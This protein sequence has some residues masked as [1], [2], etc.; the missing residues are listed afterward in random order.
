[1]KLYERDGGVFVL[2][3]STF[4]ESMRLHRIAQEGGHVKVRQVYCFEAGA[5][6]RRLSKFFALFRT[7][8]VE[9]YYGDRIAYTPMHRFRKWLEDWLHD[10][11][12]DW[13]G[14]AV[15]PTRPEAIGK[16]LGDGAG[17]VA[18]AGVERH[19][20]DNAVEKV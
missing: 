14:R 11:P 13:S 1:M 17:I 10:R 15:I 20:G 5:A 12:K 19:A 4:R 18:P 8:T 6:R 2:E 7:T 3:G 9:N 16:R